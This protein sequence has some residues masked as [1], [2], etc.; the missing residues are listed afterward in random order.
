M[1]ITHFVLIFTFTLAAML[2]AQTDTLHRA[3]ELML[4]NQPQ[5]AAML[6]ERMVAENPQTHDGFVLLGQA[7]LALQEYGLAANAFEQA[8]KLEPNDSIGIFYLAKAK[9]R[10]GDYDKAQKLLRGLLQMQPRH[11]AAK[12]QLAKAYFEANAFRKALPTYEKLIRQF[13]KNAFFYRQAAMCA[14]KINRIKTAEMYFR[15]VLQLNPN[16]RKSAVLFYNLLKN[17]QRWQEAL[18][19][20]NL[21]LTGYP[22]S[23][24]LHLA[25]GDTYLSLQKYI[26]ARQDYLKALTL[27][28]S[29]AYLYKKIGV[30]Y[31]YLNDFAAALYAL[32]TSARKKADDPLVFYF[33]GLAQKN[34]NMPDKA[35]TSFNTALMLIFPTYLP[36]LYFNLADTYT[37]KKDYVTALKYYKKVLQVDPKRKIVLF[38]MATI[39]DKYYKDLQVPL[40]YYRQFL[41]QADKQIPE[42]YKTYAMERMKAIKEKLHFQKGKKRRDHGQ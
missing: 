28:D 16:D 41:E 30:A 7:R 8:I 40:T 20:L 22:N 23:A 2:P 17:Q 6:L 24:K 19:V 37:T 34:L 31:Y 33:L 38:Y 12:I 4:K 32:Q 14:A 1:R 25:R 35:I 18:N 13:P 26:K 39:Y 29:S 21:A 10:L 27:G 11:T 15:K 5:K 3:M 36:D 9:I 42:R